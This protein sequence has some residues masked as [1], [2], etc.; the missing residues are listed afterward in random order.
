M[1]TGQ[2]LAWWQKLLVALKL[3]R[4]TYRTLHDEKK[5]ME[6]PVMPPVTG[7]YGNTVDTR[8]RRSR[9]PQRGDR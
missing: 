3:W 5:E 7:A 4:P 2:D 6:R 1:S 9:V 8:T